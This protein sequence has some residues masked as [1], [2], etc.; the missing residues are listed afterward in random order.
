MP[1]KLTE[2]I[3]LSLTHLLSHFF[4]FFQFYK[5]TFLINFRPFFAH[6]LNYSAIFR[7]EDIIALSFCYNLSA[8]SL[9]SLNLLLVLSSKIGVK[10]LSKLKSSKATMS[11]ERIYMSSKLL[12]LSIISSRSG[13]GTQLY[14]FRI[15]EAM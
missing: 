5:F 4:H 14:I 2:S 1:I 12:I 8:L 9:I 13:P 11:F 6:Y 3:N 10:S 7:Y 15:F